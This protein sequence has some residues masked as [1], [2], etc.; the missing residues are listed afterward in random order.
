VILGGNFAGLTAA[1]E[2]QRRLG[3]RARVMVI[4][5]HEQFVFIPSL[6]WMPFGWR[7]PR[8][9][10]FPLRPSLERV[11]A[12]FPQGTARR[13][14][15]ERQVVEIAPSDAPDRTEEL[16]YDYLLIATGPHVQF[17]VVS[18]LGPHGGTLRAS[19]R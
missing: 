16:R 7:T 10:M 14:D 6:I 18:G 9:I 1:Y 5:K 3:S 4:D 11:G 19:A 2:L 8:Q 12:E 15:P 17:D 13:I